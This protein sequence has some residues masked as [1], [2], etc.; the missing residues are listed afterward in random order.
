MI[1]IATI[2]KVRNKILDPRLHLLF[3]KPKQWWELWLEIKQQLVTKLECISQSDWTQ[4]HAFPI[5]KYNESCQ[6]ASHSSE[7]LDWYPLTSASPRFFD[8]K[9]FKLAASINS[10][11][12]P[13]F[14]SCQLAKW[15]C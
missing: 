11:L 12:G 13:E 3:I 1:N 15:Y 2:Y 9:H 7:G 14:G 10:L 6:I 8:Y 4:V 5:A